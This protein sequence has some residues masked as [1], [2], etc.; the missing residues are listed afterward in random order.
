MFITKRIQID[1]TKAAVRNC[2]ESYI[3][4]VCCLYLDTK[5]EVGDLG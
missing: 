5:Y 3:F 2:N 1:T 4:T